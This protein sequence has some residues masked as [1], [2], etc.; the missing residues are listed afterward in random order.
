[1]IVQIYPIPSYP[2]IGDRAE[3]DKGLT[4]FQ[5]GLKPL[6]F[7]VAV[8]YSFKSSGTPEPFE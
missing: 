4:S 7:T 6:S 5:D 1:M 3:E 8:R 2:I